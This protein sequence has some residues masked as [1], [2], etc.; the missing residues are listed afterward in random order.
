MLNNSENIS[1]NNQNTSFYNN[2]CI[3]KCFIHTFVFILAIIFAL[4][5]FVVIFMIY[6][7]VIIV[8]YAK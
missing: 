7:Y 3:D 6:Q 4:L 5:L 8:F 2:S 1:I